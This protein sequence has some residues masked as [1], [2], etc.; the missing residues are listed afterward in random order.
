MSPDWDIG[1]DTD[2]DIGTH[3]QNLDMNLLHRESKI[4]L[5]HF[6]LRKQL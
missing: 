6:H 2:T 1:T 4:G 5:Q 3:Q